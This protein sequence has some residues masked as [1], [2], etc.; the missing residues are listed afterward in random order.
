[1]SVVIRVKAHDAGDLAQVAHVRDQP[2]GFCLYAYI[3]TFRRYIY[4]WTASSLAIDLSI[5]ILIGWGLWKVRTGWTHTDAIVQRV[6][7]LTVETAFV[8]MMV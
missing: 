4:V 7:I 1:M 2:H 5:V 8:P 6:F 3:Q